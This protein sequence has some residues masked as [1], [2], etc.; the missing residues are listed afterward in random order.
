MKCDKCDSDNT[1]RVQIAYEGGTQNIETTSRTVGLGLTG[2]GLGLG[3]ASTSTSGVSRS[4][5][6]ERVAP[7]AKKG[8]QFP[9][10]FGFMSFLF[11]GMASGTMFF[12]LAGV[13]ALSAYFIFAAFKYNSSIWPSLIKH[14][15]E[16]WVCHKCGNIYHH[17]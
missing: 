14:W 17:A 12:I 4:M 3:G 16:M 8:Y 11:V 2:G 13:L 7:P 10:F 1:Q 9:V 6:A 5:L 15:Q